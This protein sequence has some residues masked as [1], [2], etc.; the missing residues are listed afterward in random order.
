M[1]ALRCR[2]R[3]EPID[4]HRRRPIRA[5]T[6]LRLRIGPTAGDQPGGGR[7]LEDQAQPR[8]VDAGRFGQ[9]LD[10]THPHAAASQLGNRCSAQNF[11]QYVDFAQQVDDGSG[12]RRIGILGCGGRHDGVGC[13]QRHRAGLLTAQ[14]LS[15]VARQD[16]RLGIDASQQANRQQVRHRPIRRR[17]G[18]GVAGTP[19]RGSFEQLVQHVAL[20]LV[21]TFDEFGD[22]FTGQ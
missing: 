8:F 3:G 13:R 9:P 2:H 10:F 14:H 21:E 4:C 5:I 7:E 20:C 19:H 18:R 22:L 1:P 16:H 12:R 17:A 15:D 11:E 6:A